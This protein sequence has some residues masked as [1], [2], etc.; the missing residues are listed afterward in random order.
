M[1][2]FFILCCLIV[3]LIGC[4]TVHLNA[5]K[6]QSVRLLDKNAA[7]SVRIEKP[8]WF[9]WW[10]GEAIDPP[11]TA[12]IIKENQLKE[13]RLYMTNTLEDSLYNVFPG[14]IGFPRRTL[15]VEGNK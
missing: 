8:V 13:V 4:G 12:T 2:R 3:S 9:K 10:G 1:Y 15:I 11:D 6:D 5:P 14:L 7:T